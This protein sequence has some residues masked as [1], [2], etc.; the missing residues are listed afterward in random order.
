MPCYTEWDAYL[1]KGSQKYKA[2]KAELEAKLKSVRHIVDYY[3]GVE[4]LQVPPAKY[5]G[6]QTWIER[7]EAEFK[8]DNSDLLVRN[9]EQIVK[10]IAHHC[11]CDGIH[12]TLIYDLVSLLDIHDK[13]EAGYARI[14]MTCANQIR[15]NKYQCDPI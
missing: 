8:V 5:S 15:A 4:G 10:N 3:Y 1:D 14:M 12:F 11:C 6:Q 2:K 9:E 7:A 13:D